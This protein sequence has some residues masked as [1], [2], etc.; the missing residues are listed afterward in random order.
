MKHGRKGT[1]TFVILVAILGLRGEVLAFDGFPPGKWWKSRQ[2]IADLKLIPSQVTQIEKLF[3]EE[4]KRLIDLKAEA[5]K[6]ELSLESLL[7]AETL[8][9]Q[10]LEAQIN[11]V[12]EAKAELNKARLLMQVKIWQLLTPEQRQQIRAWQAKRPEH[13]L[14]RPGPPHKGRE[15]GRSSLE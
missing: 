8:D 5:E 7:E 12:N 4:R 15:K 2:I 11:R 6:Q 1:R 13:H 9:Q 10:K 3:L 14:G